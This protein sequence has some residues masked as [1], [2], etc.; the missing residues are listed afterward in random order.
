M[1]IGITASLLL[2]FLIT[3]CSQEEK[4]IVEERAEYDLEEIVESDTIVAVTSYS[5]TS[6][7]L[8]RGEPMGYN[9]EMLTNFADHLDVDLEIRISRSLSDMFEMLETGEV[10]L[11]AHNLTVTGS[12]AREF[13]F[14]KPLHNTQQVLV[15]AKP[16]N[17][18]N[19][20]VNQ[21]NSQ[22]IRSP[23]E[24]ADKTVHVRQGSAYEM[25]LRHLTE[26]IGAEIDIQVAPDSITSEE[27]IA[28]VAE[29]EIDYTVTDKNLASINEA[30]YPNLDISTEISLSQN[31]AWAVRNQSQELLDH[32]NEWLENFQRQTDYYVIYNK[33]FE[34]RTAYRTRMNSDLLS[35]HSGRFSWYDGTIQRYAD[36][37]EWDWKLLA[38]LIFQESRFNPNARSGA[39]ATGL[40]QLM[41]RTARAFS[42][43]DPRNP[44]QSIRAGTKFI[45]WLS[46]Y[47]E[48]EIED[49]EER[50]K[51]ILA[52]YNTGQGHVQ[53]A[54]RLA[55]EF[56]NADPDIWTDNVERY[57]LKKSDREYFN[58]EV[59]RYGYSRGQ[60]PVNY[61]KR[62]MYIYDHYKMVAEYHDDE[63]EAELV[64]AR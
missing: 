7:F 46:N 3:S 60:E 42:A 13:A 28:K 40:M 62:I 27:L 49:E 31:L 36:Q 47:W 54:R 50:M 12:R 37:I 64:W 16:D 19:M 4:E 51:F 32:L 35:I 9:Y 43:D 22:L 20:Q 24:L 56:G 11:I 17:W 10:D 39:G 15:Q 34:N 63:P 23:L 57:M 30:Y 14:T 55:R 5:A 29:G 2:I 33:Y 41:P 61:V 58:H 44:E 45:E 38:A 59:V 8:Y 52:S 26:E 25:R 53:D 18:R 1:K 6:Y 21:I 48:K